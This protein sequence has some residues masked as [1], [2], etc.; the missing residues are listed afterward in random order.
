MNF[1]GVGMT[2]DASRDAFYAP[3]P[4]PSW[5]LVEASC[6]WE[7]PVAYPDDGLAYSWDEST[8]SWIE[9]EIL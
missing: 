7:A 6:L 5:I 8:T 3:Q 2:Y 9:Q 4:F 1:A